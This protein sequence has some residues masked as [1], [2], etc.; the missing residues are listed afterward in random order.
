MLLPGCQLVFF[1]LH[2]NLSCLLVLLLMFQTGENE[3][4]G[5]GGGGGVGDGKRNV[6]WLLFSFVWVNTACHDMF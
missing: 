2:C 4:V 3:V 1:L 5:W 6:P